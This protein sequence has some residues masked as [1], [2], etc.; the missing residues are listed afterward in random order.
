M[1]IAFTIQIISI[2]LKTDGGEAGD[3]SITI[4]SSNDG[5][6]DDNDGDNIDTSWWQ[7]SCRRSRCRRQQRGFRQGSFRPCSKGL[8]QLLV[9]MVV[10]W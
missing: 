7:L 8:P 5:N 1:V 2:M 10:I 4:L 9:Q 6:G 3:K